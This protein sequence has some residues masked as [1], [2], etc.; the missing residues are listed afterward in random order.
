MK[1]HTEPLQPDTFYHIYN[2][3]INKENIFKEERNYYFFLAKY[4]KYISPVACTYSYCLLKNHFHLLIRT[5]SSESIRTAFPLKASS[6]ID[7]IISS[8]FS[9][10]FNGYA[11]AVNK[12]FERTGGLFET[13][14]RR[15]AVTDQVYLSQLM[16]YIHSNPLKHGFTDDFTTYPWSSYPVY[17]NDDETLIGFKILSA[18]E[19]EAGLEWFG[20]RQSFIGYHQDPGKD[21]SFDFEMLTDS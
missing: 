7:K 15:I 1:T 21:S 5:R 20:D 16:Y 3:G 9:H 4:H 10:L 18:L 2:R 6:E 8:Q 13:P 19:R 11:Q 12:S 17:L 14:F